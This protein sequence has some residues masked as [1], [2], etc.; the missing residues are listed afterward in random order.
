MLRLLR[1]IGVIGLFLVGYDQVGETTSSAQAENN[2]TS[3]SHHPTLHKSL[4][5]DGLDI[6]YREAGP[7]DAPTI[8]LL[9]GFPTSS[10]MFRDLIPQLSDQFHLVAPDYPGYGNSSMPAVD[11]FDY[12]FDNLAK[13]MEKFIQKIGL[14]VLEGS[15]AI[16]PIMLFDAQLAIRYANSMLEKG[17]YV[18]PFSFPVVPKGK[19]RI[20]TQIS[21]SHSR[22][23]LQKA[24]DAFA[25]TRRE[26]GE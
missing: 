23:D 19:A 2:S 22:E 14:T 9:H 10:H 18:I 13:V 12:S 4:K 1:I 6:F 26:I 17:V 20:R 25:E 8:L 15:H 21:A 11:K 24:M 7:K 5:I 16:V 3:S